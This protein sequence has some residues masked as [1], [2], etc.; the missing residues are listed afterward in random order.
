V[1][2]L[3]LS[4]SLADVTVACED[5]FKASLHKLI[6]AASSS[7]F[8]Q[9]FED[10]TESKHPIII[11]SGISGDILKFIVSFLYSGFAEVPMTQIEQL[12]TAGK[13][14]KIKVSY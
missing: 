9:I 1:E 5:G 4:T 2:E 10:F 12:I 7:Y 6:L 14:L 13:S 8:R 11:L 3:Q